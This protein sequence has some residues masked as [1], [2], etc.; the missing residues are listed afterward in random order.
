MKSR[1][2]KRSV[3]IAGHRTSVSLEEEFWAGL[4]E[5][6]VKQGVTVSSLVAAID[7]GRQQANLSSLI[8]LLVLEHYQTRT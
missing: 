3:V 7:A 5:I 4:K 6:A 1:V 2:I 8:R